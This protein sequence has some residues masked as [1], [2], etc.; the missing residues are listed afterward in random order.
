MS[1]LG[2]RPLG[3]IA[4]EVVR[5]SNW[6]ALARMPRR[7]PHFVDGARRYF[8]PSGTY[9][10]RC[11]IRTPL[12]IVAPTLHG[13]HDMITVNEIFCREDYR[14]GDEAEVVVDIGSNIGISALYFLTRSPRG[15]LWLYE[16]VPRNVERL[17][18]NLAGYEERWQ[19]EQS[20]VADREGEEAFSVEP[21]GRYGGLGSAHG[22]SIP[23]RVRHIDDVLREVLDAESRI[24]VLKL[25]TEGVEA[26]TLAAA[27][28]ALL[29]QVR[30]IFAEDMAGEIEPPGGFES[31]RRASVLRLR[32]P[33][34]A[35]AR[36]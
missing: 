8:T 10:Y 35:A 17:R 20:A 24:D 27:D 7:Y 18:E 6:V 13:H 36:R 33:D 15:R 12:G 32:Q 28:P 30:A 23:V 29:S 4:R 34:S 19:L 3:F 1:L 25:D 9:P 22:E 26:R 16:P 21:T 5:P 14:V 2:D 31:S 11:E